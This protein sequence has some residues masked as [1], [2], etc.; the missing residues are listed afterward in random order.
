[1]AVPSEPNILSFIKRNAAIWGYNSIPLQGPTSVVCGQYC[2]LFTR[3]MDKR[4]TPLQ[5]VRLF[6]PDGADKQAVEMFKDLF[7]PIC[8]SPRGG[9]CCKPSL[10]SKYIVLSNHHFLTVCHGRFKRGVV[11][12]L[13]VNYS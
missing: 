6:P 13:F 10:L 9:Q 2:C 1:M 12:G 5:F 8:G 3:Y 4:F 7:G 11:L